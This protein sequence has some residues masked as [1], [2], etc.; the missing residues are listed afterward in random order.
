[1]S[2]SGSYAV[3]LL[4]LCAVSVWTAY[5]YMYVFVHVCRVEEN[6][7]QHTYL[8]HRQT[9][10]THCSDK[11]IHVVGKSLLN[12][13]CSALAGNIHRSL[14]DGQF[15]FYA[16]FFFNFRST[17]AANY[18]CSFF[19]LRRRSTTC[20]RVSVFVVGFVVCLLCEWI[21]LRWSLHKG[22]LNP[23]N[24]VPFQRTMTLRGQQQQQ[25]RTDKEERLSICLIY[26]A[27]DGVRDG[28]WAQGKR[29]ACPLAV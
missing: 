19:F 21:V 29:H 3:V 17:A 20:V 12:I 16:R 18:S 4:C 27:H 14:V 22:L 10:R 15:P 13:F 1:M 24:L 2:G 28:R 25:H 7:L 6:N 8:C 23:T 9:Y 5:A 11:Y 26:P